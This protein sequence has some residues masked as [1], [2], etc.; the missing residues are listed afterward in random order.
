MQEKE[1]AKKT[2]N[3][4]FALLIFILLLGMIA[5]GIVGKDYW[6]KYT[7]EQKFIKQQL[8]LLSEKQDAINN[9][10]SKFDTIEK[11]LQMLRDKTPTSEI[12]AQTIAQIKD[13][14]FLTRIADDRLLYSN[15]VQTAKQLLQL[16]QERLANINTPAAEK[17]RAILIADHKKL[18]EVNYP[19]MQEIQ[20]RLAVLDS[21]INTLPVRTTHDLDDN[22]Q[23]KNY[24]PKQKVPANVDKKWKQSLNNI[25]EDLKNVVR[26]RKKT[27][28]DPALA[29]VN[30][31]INRAQFKLLI[32]QIR[33]AVYYRD[34]A[35]YQRSIKSAQQLLTITFD[36]SNEDVKKF[37]NTLNE[38][39]ATKI[40]T[41]VPNIQ[42][43]VKAL[44]ALIVG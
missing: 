28:I 38:L 3:F 15:D 13:A 5:I 42:D 29:Y 18:E 32:E 1:K 36:S 10:E 6:L 14:Y 35:V 43:S 33:W 12:Q 39:A 11:D 41:N 31:E 22:A 34:G 7:Q 17:A 8:G 23:S 44:Q 30:E 21:L 26:V 40:Q 25:I 37:S 9:L 24:K 2:F 19:N 4:K 27:E 20:D 16:A